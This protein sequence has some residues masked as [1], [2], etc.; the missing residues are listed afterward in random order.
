MI[1]PPPVSPFSEDEQLLSLKQAASLLH[2]SRSSM[3]RMIRRGELPATRVGGRTRF[4]IDDLRA[5]LRRKESEPPD[6]APE[7]RQAE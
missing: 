5:F 4:R 1:L 2:V 7:E 6:E 3:Y